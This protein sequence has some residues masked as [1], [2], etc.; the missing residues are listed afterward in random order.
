MQKEYFDVCGIYEVMEM[1]VKYMG[2]DCI[3]MRGETP[4]T[5]HPLRV[6]FRQWCDH[7][8][9]CE[10]RDDLTI[11]IIDFAN[12]LELCEEGDDIGMLFVFPERQDH[13]LIVDC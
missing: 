12:I 4:W 3:V 10:H 8:F 11:R 13:R 6:G 1:I 5:L 7:N 9:K 2:I